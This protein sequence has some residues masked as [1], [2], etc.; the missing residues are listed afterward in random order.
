MNW[1][2]DLYLGKMAKQKKEK[3]IQ[4]IE[5]GKTPINTYLLTLAS[6]DANQ[7]EIVPAWNLKFWYNKSTLPM[8]VGI[9]CGRAEALEL[10]RRITEEVYCE[11]KDVRLREFFEQQFR[12]ASK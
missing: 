9:G 6:G 12:H 5:S 1:Y 2:P 3:L 7:L 10:V 11:T 8:I 4:K